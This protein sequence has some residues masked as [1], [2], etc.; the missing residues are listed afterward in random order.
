MN[1]HE[2]DKQ[3]LQRAYEVASENNRSLFDWIVNTKSDFQNYEIKKIYIDIPR[4][5]LLK[6]IKIRIDEMFE[7][8]MYRRGKKFNT[9]RIKKLFQ[10]TN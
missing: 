9:L 10:P 4:D 5:K 3:R 2:Y 8:K 1:I 6:N 7:A